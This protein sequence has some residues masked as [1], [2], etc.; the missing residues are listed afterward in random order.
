M[1]RASSTILGPFIRGIRER[2]S[3][4]RPRVSSRPADYDLRAMKTTNPVS[5]VGSWSV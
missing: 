2:L 1:C 4:L 3:A 5:P